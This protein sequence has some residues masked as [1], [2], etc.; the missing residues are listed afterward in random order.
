MR[1]G[2]E[3]RNSSLLNVARRIFLHSEIEAL[4]TA[5]VSLVFIT[6]DDEELN[7]FFMLLKVIYYHYL[8]FV[9][10]NAHICY[11]IKLYYRCSYM[12]R[13]F[14]TIF[15]KFDIV[16]AEVIKYQNYTKQ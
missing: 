10:T 3:R 9:P 4:S 15:R 16:F 12:F 6:D 14:C 11:N 13:C 8:L 5:P 2:E 7:K 1:L